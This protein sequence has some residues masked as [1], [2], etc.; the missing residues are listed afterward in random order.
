VRNKP[1][2]YF[3]YNCW[4]SSDGY[5]SQYWWNGQARMFVDKLNAQILWSKI[6]VDRSKA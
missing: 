1:H 2:I 5:Q 4:W 6:D 3:K